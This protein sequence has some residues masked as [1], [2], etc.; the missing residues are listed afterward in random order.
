MHGNESNIQV[1]LSAGYVFELF[2]GDFIIVAQYSP[3]ALQFVK[4]VRNVF[5]G[6]NE[7]VVMEA[8]HVSSSDTA[9]RTSTSSRVLGQ[10]VACLIFQVYHLVFDLRRRYKR[11]EP[12]WM[13]EPMGLLEIAVDR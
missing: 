12:Y 8:D 4:G 7:G 9:Q 10:A 3:R 1:V 6:Y 2:S 5:G 11:G 13:V